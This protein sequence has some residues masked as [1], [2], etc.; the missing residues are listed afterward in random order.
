[1]QRA[2]QRS[3]SRVS[4]GAARQELLNVCVQEDEEEAE[5]KEEEEEA[6]L[7]FFVTSQTIKVKGVAKTDKDHIRSMQISS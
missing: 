7:Q 4:S 2:L 1:M 6:I 5:E 3:P